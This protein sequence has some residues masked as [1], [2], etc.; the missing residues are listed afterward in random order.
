MKVKCRREPLTQ[1][2]PERE[3]EG[4]GSQQVPA[5]LCHAAIDA[6]AFL[7]Y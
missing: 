7:R 1:L 6:V 4:K 3:H 2:G 5:I